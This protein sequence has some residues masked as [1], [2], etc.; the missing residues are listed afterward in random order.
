MRDDALLR[1]VVAEVRG[2]GPR[3]DPLDPHDAVL[4]QILVQGQPAPPAARVRARFFYDEAGQPRASGLDIFRVDPVVA[5]VRIGHRDHLA[6]VRRVRQ[7]LLIPRHGGV[8]HHFADGFPR[9]AQRGALEHGPIRQREDS[10]FH[11][12]HFCT[13][14]QSNVTP[15][16]RLMR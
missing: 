4:T 9:R 1:A 10:R 13:F 8:E 2:Q 6:A 15:N 3:V 5:D 11:R 14:M 12:I 16:P 7:D